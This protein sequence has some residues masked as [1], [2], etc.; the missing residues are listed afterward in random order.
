MVY[1]LIVFSALV[2]IWGVNNYLKTID[3]PLWVKITFLIVTF[4]LF[5]YYFGSF[6]HTLWDLYRNGFEV[7]H[8]TAGG[9]AFNR[10]ID[11]LISILF[12][13]MSFF[14]SGLALNIAVK[15]KSRKLLLWTT[16]VILIVTIL[17]FYKS[18]IL[19]YGFAKSTKTFL[20]FTI[21][22]SVI[23]G[24]INLIYNLNPWEKIFI[25]AQKVD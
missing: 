10:D 11:L 23:L 15:A 24:I 5:E 1:E 2:I 13:L 14:V 7:F 19:E 20:V 16:P 25:L 12:F 21:M 17:D 4:L 8:S 6:R 22:V 18:S 3:L 9:Y